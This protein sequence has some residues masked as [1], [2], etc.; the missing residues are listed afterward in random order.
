MGHTSELLKAVALVLGDTQRLSKTQ[1]T[2][3]A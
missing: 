3:T 1:R 2:L